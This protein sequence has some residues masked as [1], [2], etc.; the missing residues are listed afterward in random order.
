MG[1]KQ[2]INNDPEVQGL[3]SLLR[4]HFIRK[5]TLKYQISKVKIHSC[6]VRFNFD[7]K[8]IRQTLSISKKLLKRIEGL[9]K[10]TSFITRLEKSAKMFEIVDY[11]SR[12][13]RRIESLNVR[14]V[15]TMD[16]Y[17][18]LKSRKVYLEDMAKCLKDKLSMR[19][20]VFK[21]NQEKIRNRRQVSNGS[22]NKS[23]CLKGDDNKHYRDS[24]TN[25]CTPSFSPI[26]T[27]DHRAKN[28]STR[29]EFFDLCDQIEDKQKSKDFQQH[30][31]IPKKTKNAKSYLQLS[32]KALLLRSK[33]LLK[34]ELQ[35][36]VE[37][38]RQRLEVKL[39]ISDEKQHALEELIH[40][41]SLTSK[42]DEQYLGQLNKQIFLLNDELQAYQSEKAYLIFRFSTNMPSDD[43]YV[44][45][46]GDDSK[47]Y[48]I[49]N[50]NF[51]VKR[52]NISVLLA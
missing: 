38:T 17:E 5:N 24:S 11:C 34:E 37:F 39:R 46:Y 36:S 33:L 27:P 20:E 45:T 13:Y 3:L 48:S 41:N 9:R 35:R 16:D 1:G 28:S 25:I 14:G 18:C 4:A 26:N 49:L 10:T 43:S 31:N 29:I 12:S 47:N 22:D 19:Q 23:I 50:G 15:N 8:G 51:G 42:I 32:E 6:Y 7:F 21:Q 40:P 44:E 30:S 52:E 2:S